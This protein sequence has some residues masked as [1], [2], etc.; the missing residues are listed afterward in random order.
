ME[1]LVDMRKDI[2]GIKE[3]VSGLK[4]DVSELK[5][6]ISELK[7]DVSELKQDIILIKQDIV[8]MKQE[9]KCIKRRLDILE[10]RIVEGIFILQESIS[11]TMEKKNKE[12]DIVISYLTNSEISKEKRLKKCEC[13]IKN[14]ESRLENK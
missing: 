14:I 7:Q 8:F 3:D 1:I 10:D 9:I 13:R 12:N 11:K 6:D 2:T 4:E 5:Q